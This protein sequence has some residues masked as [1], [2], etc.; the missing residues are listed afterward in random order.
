MSPSRNAIIV[1]LVIYLVALSGAIWGAFA[2]R[3]WVVDRVGNAESAA[4]WE[5]WKEEAAADNQREDATV[6]RRLSDGPESHEPP[7]L[8]LMRDHFP[9]IVG[10]GLLIGTLLF[11]F[12]AFV[13]HGMLFVPGPKIAEPTEDDRP[14]T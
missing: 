2:A 12:F 14:R 3:G 8:V 10:F 11:A 13:V 9:T 4:D 1:W 6:S 7:S 5:S